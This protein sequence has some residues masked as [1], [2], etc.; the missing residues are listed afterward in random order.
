MVFSLSDNNIAKL[1]KTVNGLLKFSLTSCE[2]KI[3]Q[4]V[5]TFTRH[6][7]LFLRVFGD[8]NFNRIR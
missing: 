3:R 1:L 7:R 4:K 6:N 2:R 5:Y 8:P